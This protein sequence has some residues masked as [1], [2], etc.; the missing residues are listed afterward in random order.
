MSS[1]LEEN[2]IIN[3]EE[4]PSD[5]VF[6]IPDKSPP[7]IPIHFFEIQLNIIDKPIEKKEQLPKRYHKYDSEDW[8]KES[9][10]VFNYMIHNYDKM[11]EQN[12]TNEKK[13]KYLE[14]YGRN[15]GMIDC[16]REFQKINLSNIQTHIIPWIENELNRGELFQ[17]KNWR[18][19]I[20]CEP[21]TSMLFGYRK[22]FIFNNNYLQ[23]SIERDSVEMS[24]E[25]NGIEVDYIEINEPV[26]R[27]VLIYHGFKDNKYPT[28]IPGNYYKVP[29]DEY[30]DD[31]H[32]ND[33]SL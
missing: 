21:I 25:C 15:Y 4:I 33:Y 14:I 10:E 20:H 2:T 6:I 1:Y 8:K 29:S 28:L 12:C 19:F 22:F 17:S 31:E 9:I 23:L 11:F 24:I 32:W 3:V 26:I 30:I 13:I 7:K 5:N 16:A 27:F 18:P